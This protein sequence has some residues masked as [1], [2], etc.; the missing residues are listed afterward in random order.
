MD[1]KQINSISKF[2]S[3]VLRHRPELIGIELDKEG[4]ADVNFLIQQIN[5]SGTFIDRELLDLVVETNSKKR[6]AFDEHKERIRASQGHSVAVDLGHSPQIP[7][8][9]LYHGTAEKSVSSILNAGLEK[10]ERQHVHLSQDV[11][12]ATQVGGRHGKPVVLTVLAAEMQAA[13]HLFYLSENKVWLTDYVP[14]Q[15]IRLH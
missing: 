6:F 7:P 13:G 5:A 1:T 9:L 11:Q 14:V 2:L 10:R 8:D 4:W 15:F 3:L 12:T